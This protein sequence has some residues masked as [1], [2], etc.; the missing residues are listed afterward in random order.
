MNLKKKTAVFL[1]VAG[2][3]L[4]LGAGESRAALKNPGE[5]C[6][7]NTECASG[8][9]REGYLGLVCKG[10]EEG[11]ACS[12][13]DQKLR[14]GEGLLCQGD[15]FVCVKDE[16]VG[17]PSTNNGSQAGSGVSP[18]TGGNNTPCNPN[19]KTQF[20]N[21]LRFNSVEGF[22]ANFLSALQ[23]IIVVVALIM[24][25]IG[26]LQYIT[27]MGGDQVKKGKGTI[28]AALIGM[29]I[30]VA[31]PSFLKEISVL[32]GWNAQSEAVQK[33]L[34]LTQIALNVLNFL[35]SILGVVALVMLVLGGTFYATAAVDSNQAKTGKDIVKY[36]LIGVIIA[37]ASMVLL[38]TI[39]R[40]FV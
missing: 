32:L 38:R 30:A 28:T 6:T 25:V 16:R 20:C 27:S 10:L 29:A 12:I 21:P 39:A 1:V 37:M 36:A 34:T 7:K 4:L 11:Q 24:I 40:F 15:T 18:E 14:C 13:T 23:R 22:L 26:S 33:A 3:V 2:A 5:S 19:D 35:M 9:C 17:S 31:A 8:L